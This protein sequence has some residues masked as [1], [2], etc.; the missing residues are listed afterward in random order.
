M[1]H[2]RSG[3]GTAIAYDQL[4]AGRVR[5]VLRRRPRPAR[6]G[7]R[8]GLRIGKLALYEPPFMVGNRAHLPPVDHPAQL[9]RLVAEGRRGDA[10]KFYCR[11]RPT[12]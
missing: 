9:V 10:V 6:R 5:H 2:V 12:T 3:D 11:V 4:G 7:E 8:G 1:R